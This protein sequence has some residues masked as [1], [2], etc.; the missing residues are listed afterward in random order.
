MEKIFRLLRSFIEIRTIALNYFGHINDGLFIEIEFISGD[1]MKNK[2]KFEKVK[3]IEIKKDH[4]S[5]SD[6][7]MIIIEDISSAQLE[8]I[9]YKVVISGCIMEFYCHNIVLID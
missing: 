4:Y 6:N 1:G 5:I 8:V 7:N 2:I 9:N 3:A